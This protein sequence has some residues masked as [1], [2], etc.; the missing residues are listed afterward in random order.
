MSTKKERQQTLVEWNATQAE[1]PE[2]THIHRLFEAQVQLTP[3]AIAVICEEHQL[4]YY[5]LNVRANRLAHHLHALGVEPEALVGLCVERS[6]DMIVG[7][8]GILKAGCVYVPIDPGFPPERLAFMLKDTR[9]PLLVTQEH[10]VEKLP[11]RH[12]QLVC[13]DTDWPT[14]KLQSEANPSCEIKPGQL[15]YVIYTSGSTG[16][17]K[18]VLVEHH[19]LAKHCWAMVQVYQLEA[20]DCVLQFSTFTFDASLEQILPTLAVGAKLVVRGPEIW[21]P[22][23]LLDAVEDP[24]L[25]VINLPPAYWHHVLQEWVQVPDRLAGQ[26]LR[27][28]IVG[29]DRLLPE[30]LKLWQR[31]SL[32]G[33]RLLNAY[34]PTETTITATIFDIGAAR[35]QLL[36]NIPIGRPLPHRKIYILDE[37]GIPVPPGV[38][39]E[40]YIGGD[41][42]ARGYLNR[43]GLTSERF[44]ADPFSEQLHARLY[45][46]GDLARCLP[47]GNIEFLGRADQ[48]VKIRGFRIELGE[49]EAVLSQHPAV[50]EAAVIAHEDA[51]SDKHLVAYVALQKGQ[52]ATVE[53]LKSY[54]SQRLPAYMVPSTFML[55]E[56][57][58]LMSNGKVDRRALPAPEPNRFTS[59]H[60]YVAP[61]L[62]LHYQLVQI[63]EDLLD[64]HPIG[65]KDDFF[66]LGGHSLLAIRLFDRIVQVWGKKLPYS[67]LF[68]GA[69]IEQLATALTEDVQIDSQAPLLAVQSAGKRPPFYYL[70]GQ[71]EE[72]KAFHCYP[73]A[74]ALGPEQP[75]Y[76]FKTHPLN[77]QQGLPAL[78]EIAAAHIEAIRTVQPEGPYLLG[79][80]CNGGLIAYEM[81]RQFQ[82]EG[83]AVDLLVLLDPAFLVYPITYRMY[84][85]ALER[86][87]S[88]LRIGQKKQLAWSF[89]LK[90]L[91]RSLSYTLRRR[92]DPDP[93]T[94]SELLQNYPRLFDWIASGYRPRS[95]YDGKVTFFWTHGDE[96]ERI[97]RRSRKSW[98]DL[99]INYKSEVHLIPG[100]HIT[101]RT[102]Y[103]H[104][105]AEHLDSCIR[106]AQAST[107]KEDGKRA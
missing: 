25:T 55:L 7:L 89:R 33:V 85:A 56:A 5:E 70:H 32:R 67:T 99:E 3:E 92:E 97:E 72:E 59:K 31:S 102:T 61:A 29:G 90:H 84:R 98:R 80:W 50:N 86:V 64:I 82:R 42:L 34:G 69:T 30:V 8:L 54:I 2:N 38:A 93:L 100:D 51:T 74:R 45:K 12:P 26:R 79:G 78:E 87:G 1:Y 101:S 16:Q 73:L 77:G 95:L 22:A 24:G 83:Q 21:T 36:E 71:W 63:W 23:D 10:L 105:L 39:G 9:A 49:I 35:E 47:D 53:D 17:P 20:K 104:V 62:P 44:I 41:L 88:L 106:Q 11:E 68:A 76:I 60:S 4:T 46:T 58:P 37:A 52:P 94:Q 48:Q 65:I 40:L 103:L 27:L 66:D 14:I 6:M 91:F 57:L 43:P 107:S 15:A 96:K 19:A 28:V 75:F 81:A 18:G 13:L